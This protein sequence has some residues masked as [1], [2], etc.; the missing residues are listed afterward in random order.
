MATHFAEK[1]AIWEDI[2]GISCLCFMCHQLGW[3][4]SKRLT[5]ISGN[6][7]LTVSL[8]HIQDW[9]GSLVKLHVDLSVG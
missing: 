3:L 8:E 1:S 9:A 4:L 7:V 6:L 2:L 5:H